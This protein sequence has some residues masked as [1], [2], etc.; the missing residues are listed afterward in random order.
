MT[1]DSYHH[2]AEERRESLRVQRSEF[3]AIAFP[4]AD[5][6]GFAVRLESIQREFHD[7]THHCWAWRLFGGHEIR[8]R[9]SDAGEPAGTAG[10]PILQAIASEDLLDAGVVV[11]RYFGGVKLGTGGLGRAYRDA[12]R[13]V[14]RAVATKERILYARLDVTAGFE[15]MNEIYRMIAPPDV[16][17]VEERFEEQNHFVLDIRL[18]RVDEVTSR[19]GEKRFVFARLDS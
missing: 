17:L 1:F 10:K 13:E 9:S 4:V 11:I 2:P 6:P 7:A 15:T 14:L 12:A 19:L 8:E 16:I 18:S 3:I 5:E